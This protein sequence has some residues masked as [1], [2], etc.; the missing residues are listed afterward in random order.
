M[1]LV[2]ETYEFGT[3]VNGKQKSGSDWVEI[4]NPYTGELAGR[5]ASASVE[6]AERVMERT[7]EAKIR[8]SRHERYQIL[9]KLAEKLREN[10]EEIS[11]LITSESGLCLQDTSHE[12]NRAVDVLR[13]AA[14]RS[15]ED[16]S[17]I[18]PCDVSD[19]GRSRRIYTMREPF[20]LIAAITPFNHPL[21][22][23]VHKIAPAIATN[24]TVVLKPSIR[25]PIT[26]FYFAQLCLDSGLPT[27][28]LNVVCG[29]NHEISKTLVKSDLVDL[30]SYTGG[31][32]VGKKI[33]SM[34]GYKRLI[35]ELGGGSAMLVLEDAEVEQ[36]VDIAMAGIFKNGGQRC[37]AIRRLVVH[38]SLA[39]D[40]AGQL[41]DKVS[42]ITYG[43]PF[44]PDIQMG[45]VINE[46]AAKRIEGRVQNAI[47][48][49]AELL[50]GHKREGAL[51][52]PTVLDF[53]KNDYELV[54]CETFG[55]VAPIIR[56]ETLDEA[57]VIA[58]DNPYGLTGAVVSNHWPSIQRVISELE[59]GT[60]NV[61]I[62]PSYRLEWSPFGGVKDSGL[63]DKEGVIEAMKG[64]TRVKTYSLPWDR[65]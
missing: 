13:F 28:M 59:T 63:G 47:D 32:E 55:P 11:H 16:D 48:Q 36:A 53:V 5:V 46:E 37:S 8:L 31:S 26:A 18:F 15:L 57:I 10:L 58:N 50:T 54:N 61:N 34:A 20:N 49:G 41:A 25:T 2:E 60:V 19:H 9:N 35:L 56:F 27:N 40:F 23:V 21:N 38:D 33:A 22:Q 65:P 45:T 52:S 42:D 12:V 4:R 6:Q 3:I 62:E 17:E 24:N 7:R 39:G 30:I 43:D 1:S 44:D 29:K 64:M 14:I 51:Y